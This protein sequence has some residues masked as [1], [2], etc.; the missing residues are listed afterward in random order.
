MRTDMVLNNHASTDTAHL[1]GAPN[2]GQTSFWAHGVRAEA[3]QNEFGPLLRGK[4]SLPGRFR[5][6]V[7]QFARQDWRVSIRIT[8][9]P[10]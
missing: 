3:P 2:C 5:N 8:L 4:V 1:I 6:G 7:M 10:V 9:T